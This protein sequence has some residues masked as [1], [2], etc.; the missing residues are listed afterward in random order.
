MVS[1]S[2]LAFCWSSQIPTISKLPP[3]PPIHRAHTP[4]HSAQDVDQTHISFFSWNIAKRVPKISQCSFVKEHCE[5]S[6]IVVF[7]LQ[8]VDD[9]HMM[10]RKLCKVLKKDYEL[11][12]ESA[13]GGTQL[14]IFARKSTPLTIRLENE[15]DVICGLGNVFHNKGALGAMFNIEGFRMAFM[16]SHLAAHQKKVTARNS[17]YHRIIQE[18]ENN[19]SC[20]LS[21]IDCILWGGDLNYRLNLEREEVELGLLSD[22]IDELLE[23]DQLTIARVRNDAFSFFHEGPIHFP[24]T[25]KFDKG[26]NVYDTSVKRR[27]PA[28]T[29]RILFKDNA[30]FLSLKAYDSVSEAKHSDHR[31]VFARFALKLPPRLKHGKCENNI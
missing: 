13:L 7:G 30:K 29:D 4:A 17:D 28:W 19:L 18:T 26:K 12:H 1:L 15:W 27:V 14:I 31:P 21:D 2:F 10:S 8:E 22:Q 5:G 11:I 9:L 16:T 25:Y 24:P 3:S 20:S 23:Y 6:A